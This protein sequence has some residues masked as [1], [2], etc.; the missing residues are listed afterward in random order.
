[1]DSARGVLGT[2]SDDVAAQVEGKIQTQLQKMGAS[3]DT[4]SRLECS[5]GTLKTE[6]A[7]DQKGFCSEMSETLSQ[8][9]ME[10]LKEQFGK[11]TLAQAVSQ[12]QEHS[13]TRLKQQKE[14][15]NAIQT[16]IQTQGEKRHMV[17]LVTDMKAVF[18]KQFQELAEESKDQIRNLSQHM[19]NQKFLIY[20]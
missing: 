3:L 17:Q 4:L 18:E 13:A 2:L 9:Y 11:V 5:V 14:Q 12:L 15:L 19:E 10:R 16:E 7:N 6:L 20:I 1:M 8:K